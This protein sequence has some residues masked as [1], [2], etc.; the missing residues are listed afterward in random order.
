[1]TRNALAESSFTEDKMGKHVCLLS[2]TF[3]I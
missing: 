2:A 1:M 3:Y